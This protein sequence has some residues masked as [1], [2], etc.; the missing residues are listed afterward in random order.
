MSTKAKNKMNTAG[1]TSFPVLALKRPQ[2]AKA[3]GVSPATLD[4][5]VERGLIK[6]SRAGRPV[7]A[8]EELQRYLRETAERITI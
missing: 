1:T 3:I 5:L 6:P 2:A 4:R 8:V 7:Y